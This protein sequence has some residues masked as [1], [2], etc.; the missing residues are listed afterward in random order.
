MRNS[1]TSTRNTPQSIESSSGINFGPVQATYC[2]L[3]ARKE[4]PFQQV[5]TEMLF[6]LSL[7]DGYFGSTSPYDDDGY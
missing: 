6:R 3:P 7:D 2:L 4:S 5:D 1:F